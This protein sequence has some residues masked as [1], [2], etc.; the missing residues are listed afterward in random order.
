MPALESMRTSLPADSH[1]VVTKNRLLRVAVQNMESEEDRARWEGLCGQKGMNAFVFSTEEGIRDSVKAYN[2]L[3]K[4]LKVR[5]GVA[6][7]ID[8]SWG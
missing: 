2:D 7:C 8:L 3:L 4:A 5:C 6:S 1:M